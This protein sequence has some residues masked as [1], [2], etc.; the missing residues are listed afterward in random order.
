M[1]MDNRTAVPD[2]IAV[3]CLLVPAEMPLC[4]CFGDTSFCTSAPSRAI[5]RNSEISTNTREGVP[6]CF[7]FFSCIPFFFFCLLSFFHLPNPG[8]RGLRNVESVSI[9][10]T[11]DNRYEKLATKSCDSC[12][13]RCENSRPGSQGQAPR[14]KP[15]T[16]TVA[17]TTT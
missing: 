5:T 8:L 16:Q 9:Q 1:K 4:A 7:V 2:K 11:Y 13:A 3:H 15:K 12:D 6:H 17:S 14:A 10:G